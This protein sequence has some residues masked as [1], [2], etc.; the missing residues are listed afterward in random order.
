MLARSGM[1]EYFD[2]LWRFDGW[3]VS[4]RSSLMFKNAYNMPTKRSGRFKP[5]LSKVPKGLVVLPVRWQPDLQSTLPA[6]LDSVE[7]DAP[8][9]TEPAEFTSSPPA[10][11]Q[12]QVTNDDNPP[13]T[14]STPNLND[15]KSDLPQ[16]STQDRELLASITQAIF[17]TST[18]LPTFF[19][20]PAFNDDYIH[21]AINL[22]EYLYS[23]EL[24]KQADQDQSLPRPETCPFSLHPK[25]AEEDRDYISALGK[26]IRAIA[27]KNDAHQGRVEPRPEIDKDGNLVGY[28]CNVCD[29]YI[30]NVRFACGSKEGEE[31]CKVGAQAD[32]CSRECFETRG[33]EHEGCGGKVVLVEHVTGTANGGL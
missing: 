6:T 31:G 29:K 8:N 4:L 12:Y 23:V 22:L 27:A 11:K 13:P 3:R 30:S 7:N 21:E 17:S 28:E 20:S 18:D 5:K 9:T 32:W 16:V 2:C 33:K 1:F 14:P 25:T 10:L 19:C 24:Q 26:R 15:L